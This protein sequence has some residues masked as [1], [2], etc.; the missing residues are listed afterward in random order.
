MVL[1]LNAGWNLIS[2]PKFPQDNSIE[3]LFGDR[4]DRVAWTWDGVVNKFSTA[5]EVTQNKGVW[6]YSNN[7]FLNENAGIINLP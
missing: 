2:L 4:I 5:S 1:E 3:D 6:V 7:D